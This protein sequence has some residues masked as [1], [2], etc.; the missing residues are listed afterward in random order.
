MGHVHLINV[1]PEN[2]LKETLFCVKNTSDP[3]FIKKNEWY[4]NRFQE[5]LR[6]RILKNEAGKPIGFIEYVPAKYAWRPINAPSYLF[7]HCMFVYSNN[8]K[9]QG[10]GSLMLEACKS[11]AKSN[12]YNGICV[13]TSEGSW[14]TNKNIFLQNGYSQIDKRDRFEL[15]VKKINTKSPDPTLNNWTLLQRN[16]K[17]WNLVYA[18]QCPWHEKSVLA[19]QSVAREVGIDLKV[20][21]LISC[22]E[23]QCAPSGFGVFSLL[24]DG[25]L[26]EDH[27]LSETR[28]RNILAKELK[29]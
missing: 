22:K 27:Y 11:D 6:I 25:K 10:Y 19:L 13:I 4:T 18:D 15:L 20:Q 7:I 29:K 3:G 23:A 1:T 24:N 17:G 8:D 14:I 9:H 5:G 2:V 28:F 16:Y 21:K 26:I 12:G